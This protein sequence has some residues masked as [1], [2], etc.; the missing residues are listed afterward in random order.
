MPQ[1]PYAQFLGDKDPL[2]VIAKTPDELLKLVGDIPAKMLKKPIAKGKWSVYEILGHLAD[3]EVM[4]STRC[5]LIAFDKNP[6]LASF[7]QD[8]WME[9]WR[10]E[11]EPVEDTIVRFLALRES[12]IRLFKKLPPAAWKRK[13]THQ[14]AGPMTLRDMLERCAGHDLNHLAQLRAFAKSLA[15]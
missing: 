9:G 14:E 6:V 12:Q 1:N 3:C 5:R 11:K 2:K 13:G 15:A 10:R 7:D 8:Q 4:F